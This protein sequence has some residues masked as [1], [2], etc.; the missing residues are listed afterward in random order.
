MA[1]LNSLDEIRRCRGGKPQPPNYEGER[2][3]REVKKLNYLEG[4]GLG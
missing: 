3:Y 2:I 4:R 1:D